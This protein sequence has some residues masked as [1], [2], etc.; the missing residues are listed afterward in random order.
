MADIEIVD[1]YQARCY[2]CGWESPER[3][4][5]VDAETDAGR[6]RGDCPGPAA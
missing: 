1:F 5:W 6:H 4:Y 2:D 3:V